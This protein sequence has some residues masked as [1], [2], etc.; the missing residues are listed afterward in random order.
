MESSFAILAN[1]VC[2]INVSKSKRKKEVKIK[3]KGHNIKM[4][5]TTIFPIQSAKPI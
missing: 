5:A 1:L 4:P 2:F 3:A